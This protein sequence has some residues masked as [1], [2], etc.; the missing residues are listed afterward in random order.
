M[1]YEDLYSDF[2]SLF[3]EDMDFFKKREEETGAD[4]ADGIHV[5]F[6]MV[7]VP[8]ITKI[9]KE[10]PDKAKKAFEFFEEM[11]TSGDSQIAEVLEF[12]VL[13]NLLTED[14]GMIPEYA[15]YF[16]EET[17]AAATAVGKW[18]RP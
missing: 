13:E 17:K 11:E 2:I 1:K 12:T 5:V 8:F 10:T 3:P 18:F 6:G 7:V 14:K 9:V 16:G 4:V 15:K